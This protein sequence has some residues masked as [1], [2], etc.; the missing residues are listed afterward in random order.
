MQQ[1]SLFCLSSLPLTN[2]ISTRCTQV[3]P[4]FFQKLSYSLICK[5][6]FQSHSLRFSEFCIH[7]DIRLH[8]AFLFELQH[9]VQALQFH[10][11][12]SDKTASFCNAPHSCFCYEE[13]TTTCCIL[14]VFRS[15]F[16]IKLCWYSDI[17]SFLTCFFSG[18]R[19]K[20]LCS[21]CSSFGYSRSTSRIH[22]F[23]AFSFFLMISFLSGHNTFPF[24]ISFREWL[25]HCPSIKIICVKIRNVFVWS[26]WVIVR[27]IR[28]VCLSVSLAYHGDSTPHS[29]SANIYISMSVNNSSLT[30]I[31]FNKASQDNPGDV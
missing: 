8:P 15:K 21:S 26:A 24:K 28:V 6:S 2:F 1:I 13:S 18:A 25:A 20:L 4:W 19:G 14:G 27:Y 23:F 31:F 9:L 17:H 16:F 11:L 29:L 5:N 3:F 30:P 22:P 10:S 12:D 7:P